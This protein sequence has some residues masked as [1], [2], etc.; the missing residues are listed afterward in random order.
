LENPLTPE[1]EQYVRACAR[2]GE[3]PEAWFDFYR[4][5]FREVVDWDED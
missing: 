4:Y 1:G 2:E 3:V 5:L